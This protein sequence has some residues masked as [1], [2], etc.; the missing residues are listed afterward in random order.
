MSGDGVNELAQ[1]WAVV[2]GEDVW[3]DA[4]AFC[5]AHS[6]QAS[7]ALPAVTQLLVNIL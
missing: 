7:C 5:W 1:V 2:V 3:A 4:A 6:G